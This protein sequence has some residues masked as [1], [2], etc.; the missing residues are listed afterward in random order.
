ML[1]YRIKSRSGS[2]NEEVLYQSEIS[3]DRRHGKRWMNSRYN[4]E[5]D[6]KDYIKEIHVETDTDTSPHIFTHPLRRKGGRKAGRYSVKKEASY[7]SQLF[8]CCSV[9]QSVLT[10]CNPQDCSTWGFPVLHHLGVCSNSCPL[11]QWCHPTISPNFFRR[12]HNQDHP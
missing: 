1:G 4:R 2:T 12:G 10:L 11:S 6:L 7:T 5:V 8:C 3:R 9:A